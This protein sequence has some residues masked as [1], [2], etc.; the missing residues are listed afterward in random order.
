MVIFFSRSEEDVVEDE[1][2]LDL[3]GLFI[4]VPAIT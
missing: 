3:Y 1:A 2:W 4:R